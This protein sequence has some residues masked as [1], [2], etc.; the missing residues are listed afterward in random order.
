MQ[1][2]AAETLTMS[3][4]NDDEP[5]DEAGTIAD[6]SG[7]FLQASTSLKQD[8]FLVAYAKC[9]NI[10]RA[11]ELAI[12]AR[13]SH[14]KW[15]RNVPGYAARFNEAKAQ[16]RAAVFEA[17]RSRAIDGW[18]EPIFQQGMLVGYKRRFDSSLLRDLGRA[19][20]PDVF[21]D[22]KEIHHTGKVE[23]DHKVKFYLPDN[24][25]DGVRTIECDSDSITRIPDQASDGD[26]P[27]AGSAGDDLVD[28]G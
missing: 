22:K 9:G 7:D 10:V 24:Q 13:D 26:S 21:T 4:A 25:R 8:A 28:P 12:C 16:F 5:T 2:Y 18:D 23:H 14:Y 3:D 6:A 27:A 20:L 17:I 1:L 19:V 11:A 15:K